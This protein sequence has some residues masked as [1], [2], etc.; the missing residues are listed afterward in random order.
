MWRAESAAKRR[1]A[2]FKRSSTAECRRS[3]PSRGQCLGRQNGKSYVEQLQ[4]GGD[5]LDSL[6]GGMTEPMATASQAAPANTS[7]IAN[8]ARN[9]GHQKGFDGNRADSS[10]AGMWSAW[11]ACEGLPEVTRPPADS[12]LS[13][14]PSQAVP[15]PPRPP[16]RTASQ[17]IKFS[18]AGSGANA[19]LLGPLPYRGPR[20]HGQL[21]N[22][23]GGTGGLE[24]TWQRIGNR[25]P[26]FEAAPWLDR[27]NAW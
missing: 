7:G 21:R 13:R 22:G 6:E 11:D 23:T 8:S 19:L 10:D 14:K 25:R 20:L 5:S 9:A 24:A 27:R 3:V 16:S 4:D 17:Q 26:E 15:E 12:G 1:R 2:S 18:I